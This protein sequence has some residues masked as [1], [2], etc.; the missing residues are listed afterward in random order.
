MP[1]DVAARDGYHPGRSTNEAQ[2]LPPVA[3]KLRVNQQE[4]NELGLITRRIDHARSL[5]ASR[6]Q[7]AGIASTARPALPVGGVTRYRH[8]IINTQRQ[9]F[10]N[11]LGLT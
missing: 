7:P 5:E 4:R 6:P 9:A 3:D 2:T 1:P 11:D 10:S 8:R